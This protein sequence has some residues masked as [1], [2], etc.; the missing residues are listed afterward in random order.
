MTSKI[1][2]KIKTLR[3]KAGVTQEKFADYL[4]ITFQSVSRWESGICYPDLEML[5]SIANYF[6]VTTD[7]LLGVDIMNKQEK[8][9]EIRAKLRENF[10][11]GFINENI[12]ICRAA[13]NEFPNDFGLLSDLALYLGKRTDTIKEAISV[14]ERILADCADDHIRYGVMQR[15]AHNYNTTGEKE[16]AVNVAKKLPDIIF[17]SNMVLRN[18]YEGDEKVEHLKYNIMRFC[19]YIA[20][21]ITNLAQ[22]KYPDDKNAADVQKRIE[23]YKKA[24]TIFSIIYEEGDY[25]LYGVKMKD[26]YLGIAS[27]YVL[28]DDY[29]NAAEF[30]EKAADNAI[31]FDT[32][33]EVFTHTSTM[34]GGTELSK[35]KHL[36]KDDDCN[37]SYELLYKNLSD[38]RYDAIRGSERFKAVVARLQQYAKKEDSNLPRQ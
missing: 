7:E 36:V 13:V 3:K 31:A 8:I 9:N 10:S 32:L 28:L 1:G 2:E 16:K 22:T 17:A 35:A 27:F 11:K 34:F 25:G 4:G 26:L 30:T 23:L 38:R 29:E 6:N 5:P 21:D 15:L 37:A 14:N 24:I 12:E 18:I 33:P 20:S 19:D